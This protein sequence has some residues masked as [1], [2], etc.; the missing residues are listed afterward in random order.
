MIAYTPYHSMNTVRHDTALFFFCKYV[1]QYNCR[2]M[3]HFYLVV[4]LLSS[5]IA[6]QRLILRCQHSAGL[7]PRPIIWDYDSLRTDLLMPDRSRFLFVDSTRLDSRKRGLTVSL[8][9]TTMCLQDFAFLLFASAGAGHVIG[10]I[11]FNQNVSLA[12]PT[13]AVVGSAPALSCLPL[14]QMDSFLWNKNIP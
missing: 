3:R 14:A 7:A 4:R 11:T 12:C 6:P 2:C 5:I 10:T 9:P 8:F 13:W 1:I